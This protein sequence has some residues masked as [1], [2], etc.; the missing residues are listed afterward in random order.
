M[1]ALGLIQ[2]PLKWLPGTPE[3]EVTFNGE[4]KEME[5]WGINTTQ[6]LALIDSLYQFIR[7]PLPWSFHERSPVGWA[8][9]AITPEVK[10]T[11]DPDT[12]LQSNCL[13]LVPLY[14]NPRSTWT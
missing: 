7:L 8:S 9:K 12:T 2:E 1:E 3:P 13:V 14:W 5:A 11:S 10:E 6:L 4:S